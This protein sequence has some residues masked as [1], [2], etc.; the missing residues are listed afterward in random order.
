MSAV[1]VPV[2]SG[3]LSAMQSAS[4]CRVVS[5]GQWMVTVGGRVSSTVMVCWQVARVSLVS[6]SMV[7]AAE[8]VA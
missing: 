2:F 6:Q 1:A 5:F 7:E 8:R 4:E 3:W